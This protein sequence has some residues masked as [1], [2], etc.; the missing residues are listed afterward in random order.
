MAKFLT[1]AREKLRTWAANKKLG[2]SGLA[3]RLG[4]NPSLASRWLSGDSRPDPA[5]R[6]RL[7]ELVGIALRDWETEAEKERR[8]RE[9]LAARKAS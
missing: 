4:V 8:E 9:G 2:P 5:H 6:E 7:R 3:N 1:P